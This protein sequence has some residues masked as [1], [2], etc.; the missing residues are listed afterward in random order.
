MEQHLVHL[1]P[2]QQREELSD[3]GVVAVANR[4]P[5]E[6]LV[7]HGLEPLVVGDAVPVEAGL[8]GLGVVGRELHEGVGQLQQVPVGHLG[9]GAVAVA[10]GPGVGGVR[11]PVGVEALEPPVGPV[12]D[13]EAEDRHVVGVQHAVHEADAHPVHHQ[14][15][16][17]LGYLCEEG[18][19]LRR[20]RFAGPHEAGEIVPHGEVDELAQEVVVAPRRRQLEAAEPRE[21]GCD[22]AHDCAR[23]GRR[24]A[25]VEDVA[26]DVVAGGQQ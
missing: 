17:A 14:R 24:V 9:L 3:E 12:V 20:H 10:E 26:D 23:F 18:G 4:A 25:V 8:Q 13:R 1:G 5:P 22:P 11:R 7:G 16:R 2:G 21:R 15:R 19:H 6:A